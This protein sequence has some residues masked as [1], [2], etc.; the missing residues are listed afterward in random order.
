MAL[1]AALAYYPADRDW[2]SAEIMDE[3]RRLSSTPGW[4]QVWR[5]GT[6]LHL[7]HTA[8]TITVAGGQEGDMVVTDGPYA[9][10]KEVLA[11]FVLLEAADLDEA[12][13]WA[14]QIPTA[15]HGKVELRPVLFSRGSAAG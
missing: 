9:E 7:A 13:R 4:S 2:T 14:A 6:A 5:G 1:Y 8:T 3:Y 11:G 10:A 12:M 15:W